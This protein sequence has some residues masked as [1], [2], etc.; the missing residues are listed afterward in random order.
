[1]NEVAFDK[2][3]HEFEF[4]FPVPSF[5]PQALNFLS[6]EN[7]RINVEHKE[8]LEGLMNGKIDLFFECREKYFV[9]DWKSNFLGASLNAYSKEKLN[10][11][12]NE[13][14]YPKLHNATWPGIVGK[15]EGSEPTISLDTLLELTAAAEV[16]G[17][18]FDGI[19]IDTDDSRQLDH[20]R[21]NAD[22]AEC[23]TDGPCGRGRRP[24]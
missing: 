3:I 7:I 4:D 18:K 23:R 17:V 9:L 1:M 12:M 15:G 19:D 20:Q 14:N 24:R 13:N 6:N 22:G 5:N 2:R 16:N 11:A 21:D 8:E 10:E